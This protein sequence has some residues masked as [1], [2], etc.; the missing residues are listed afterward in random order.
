L[1]FSL[2]QSLFAV[3][4]VLMVEETAASETTIVDDPSGESV[5]VAP[6]LDSEEVLDSS[7]DCCL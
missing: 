6:V 5:S 2:L 3:G 7:L 4:A 1:H